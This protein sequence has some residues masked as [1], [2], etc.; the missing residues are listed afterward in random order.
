MPAYQ[1]TGNDP[2]PRLWSAGPLEELVSS[3]QINHLILIYGFLEWSLLGVHQDSNAVNLC[4]QGCFP[5]Y[6]SQRSLHERF[7]WLSHSISGCVPGLLSIESGAFVEPSI[8][9]IASEACC[10]IP[11]SV[12]RDQ[13]PHE[14]LNLLFGVS[15]Q[16]SEPKLYH[17][18]ETEVVVATRY[19]GALSGAIGILFQSHRLISIEAAILS[20]FLNWPTGNS[21]MPSVQP[22]LL[23]A[24]FDHRILVAQKRNNT[25]LGCNTFDAASPE[26]V[27]YYALL[28]D[29]GLS[30]AVYLVGFDPTE[31]DL[32]QAKMAESFGDC[33][34]SAWIHDELS[35]DASAS[36]RH[37]PNPWMPSLANFINRNP[38]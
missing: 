18:P 1:E 9:I 24:R 37:L 19:N 31:G 20:R 10:T 23:I 34:N 17:I 7:K 14:S 30:K 21:P 38:I 33:F 35:T 13:L 4:L 25:L 2:K 3:G 36:W 29:Q 28:F 16:S 5:D 27:L 12:C 11:L 26:E 8:V 6:W 32:L 22:V 15:E